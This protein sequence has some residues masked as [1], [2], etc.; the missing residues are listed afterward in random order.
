MPSPK[1]KSIVPTDV[2][3]EV[4]GRLSDEWQPAWK[5]IGYQ[6]AGQEPVKGTHATLLALV[7]KG[8]AERHRQHQWR[9]EYRLAQKAAPGAILLETL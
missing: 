3:R 5:L 4:L 1:L 8:Y 7:K 6:I 9:Y 2:Q